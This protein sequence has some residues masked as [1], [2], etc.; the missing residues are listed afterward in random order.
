MLLVIVV[1]GLSALHSSGHVEDW[2][3]PAEEPAELGAAQPIFANKFDLVAGTVFISSAAANSTLAVGEKALNWTLRAVTN[4]GASQTPT[5]VLERNWARWGALVYLQ[6]G[7]QEGAQHTESCRLAPRNPCVFLRKGVGDVDSLKRPRYDLT[8]SDKDYFVNATTSTD[9]YLKQLFVNSTADLEPTF[10]SAASVLSPTLDYALIKNVDAHSGFSVSPQGR[11]MAANFSIREQMERGDAPRSLGGLLLFDPRNYLPF[12]WPE[13]NFSDFKSAMLGRVT[14]AVTVGVWDASS[15]KGFTL[16]AAPNP[17]RGIAT[18]PYDRAELVLRLDAHDGEKPA[19]PQYFAVESCSMCGSPERRGKW[20][21]NC[22]AVAPQAR[23][24]ANPQLIRKL[25]GGVF[26]KTLLS[27]TTAWQS[28]HQNI[29]ALGLRLDGASTEGA[30]LV[31]TARSVISAGLSTFINL[32]PNYGDGSVYWSVA[33]LDRGALPL[34]SFALNH[35]LI[36]WGHH[37]EAADR[38]E[39]YFQVYVRNASGLTPQNVVGMQRELWDRTPGKIDFKN[40]GPDS[41][42]IWPVDYQKL[43]QDS[44][45]DYGRFLDLWAEVAR[46]MEEE[47]PQW[48]QR[49]FVTARTMCSYLFVLHKNATQS[50]APHPGTGLIVGP[51]E[52]DTCK[53][54]AAFFSINGW[55]LRGWIAVQ[56]FLSDTVA[57]N[58][59]A[60]FLELGVHISQLKHDLSVAVEGSLVRKDGKSFFLPPYAA[61]GFK[62]YKT[63]IEKTRSHEPGNGCPDFAATQCPAVEGSK[64]DCTGFAG[65]PTYAGFR[66]YSEMLGS[67]TLSTDVAIAVNEFRET[68]MG[69]LSGMTRYVDHLDDMPA[70]GYGHSAVALG[71]TESALALYYGHI[72]N[73]QSRGVFNAPEQLGLYG[74][75]SPGVYYSDSFR[76]PPGTNEVDK[77]ICVP[78]TMLPAIMLRW[79]VLFS[80]RDSDVIALFRALPRRFFKPGL[81]PVI[82][83]ERG[84]TRYGHVTAKLAVTPVAAEPNCSASALLDVSLDLHGR[85]YTNRAG[86]FTLEMR[87]R[88]HGSC[89]AHRT[90]STAKASGGIR[91]HVITVDRATETVKLHF[92]S[93]LARGVYTF[94]VRATFAVGSG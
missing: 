72:A 25:T 75:G 84:A 83:L 80:E 60:F 56:R 61:V 39:F 13:T 12:T 7:F 41:R 9:D 30:R 18:Q 52:H 32:R 59:E 57:V 66:Y 8:G 91:E 10:V 49:T 45:S 33:G 67:G 23:C 78:S 63:M 90:L 82:L 86:G 93:A 5:A 77:D 92:A 87:L 21:N 3:F 94:Q 14:R 55:A 76:A 47:D 48:I 15:R 70:A 35:A 46:A 37:R 89:S 19:A 74:D 4:M 26:Y 69:T 36:L 38:I 73:Y 44:L 58:D 54:R 42:A 16:L 43:F 50:R 31:D 11:V 65:G 2:H 6:E 53:D 68:H 51:A 27:H 40:W 34:Q 88:G 17:Q 29:T 22:S 71:R 1:V 28:F 79:M 20:D 85:G 81:S 62:P 24:G 64:C